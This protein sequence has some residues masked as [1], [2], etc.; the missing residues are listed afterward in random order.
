[1]AHRLQTVERADMIMILENGRLREFG[2]YHQLAHDPTS[3]FYNLRQ[4]GL[5]EVLA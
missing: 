2:P 3:R 4:T 5:E 1:V